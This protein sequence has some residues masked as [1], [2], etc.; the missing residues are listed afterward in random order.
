MRT[1]SMG[2]RQFLQQL[3]GRKMSETSVDLENLGL[4]DGV[5]HLEA[6][7]LMHHCARSHSEAYLAAS[8]KEFQSAMVYFFG[9]QMIF[10]DSFT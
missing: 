1:T 5:V 6:A 8:A 3:P 7:S 4:D 10:F 2:P 9:C